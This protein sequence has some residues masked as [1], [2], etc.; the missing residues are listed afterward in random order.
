LTGVE[1]KK[2]SEFE[3]VQVMFLRTTGYP[4]KLIG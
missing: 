2:Y 1:W 3:F 4:L